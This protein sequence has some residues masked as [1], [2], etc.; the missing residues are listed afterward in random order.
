M[1]KDIKKKPQVIL[2]RQV[3]VKAVVTEKFKTFLRHELNENIK[4]YSSRLTTINN[5]LQTLE[6][7]N[8]QATQ[9]KMDKSEA[10][11]YVKSKDEQLKFIDELELDSLYSQGPV[12][13]FVT[14]SAGDNLYEKL[15][16]VEMIVEDGVVKKLN[17]VPS[18]FQSI[19]D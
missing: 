7:G 18:Q 6:V 11:S 3:N 9:L 17:N 4:M 16:G 14:I 13:G 2:K 15:G 12:E 19:V 10:E 5:Q 8:P 1:T